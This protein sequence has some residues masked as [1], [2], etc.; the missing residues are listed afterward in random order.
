M[1]AVAVQENIRELILDAVDRLLARYGYKKMTIDD[2]AHEVGIGKGTIYLHFR[3]KEEIV[4]SHI[5]RVVAGV[6]QRLNAIAANDEAPAE[7]IRQ[8]LIARVMFRFESVQHFSESLSEVLRDLRQGLLERRHRYFEQ[9]AEVIAIV[10]K[11]GQRTRA[12]RRRDPV[13]TARALVA[14]TNSLLP[15]NLSTREL[16]KRKDVE[17]SVHQIA[18]LLLNGL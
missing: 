15:F 1:R 9:E 7:K 5:D 14:A 6:L 8:M 13:E 16:G 18:D 12:F 3:S 11:E 17:Q 4:F 2:L 10:L